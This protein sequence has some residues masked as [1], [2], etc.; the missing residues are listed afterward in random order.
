MVNIT[1][2][3]SYT[4]YVNYPAASGLVPGRTLSD[5]FNRKFLNAEGAAIGYEQFVQGN[6]LAAI[7][8]MN[9]LQ[10]ESQQAVGNYV[11]IHALLNSITLT[12]SAQDNPLNGIKFKGGLFVEEKANSRM[13]VYQ[14]ISDELQTAI[15]LVPLS[16]GIYYDESVSNNWSFRFNTGVGIELIDSGISLD[17]HNV[18]MYEIEVLDNMTIEFTLMDANGGEL[19]RGQFAA[20]LS[21]SPIDS[22]SFGAVLENNDGA[23]ARTDLL[24][25]SVEGS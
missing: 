18:V 15:D 16:F 10:L 21:L 17:V 23:T 6:G 20:P 22:L 3:Y 4:D 13:Y 19:F 25:W 14:S 9:Y 11:S 24:Y 8:N 7:R 5:L 1:G 2:V 12:Y